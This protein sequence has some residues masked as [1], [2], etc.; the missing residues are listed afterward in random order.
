MLLFVNFARYDF[1]HSPT[2][3]GK[4][5]TTREKICL[6]KLPQ[7]VLRDALID[8]FGEIKHHRGLKAGGIPFEPHPLIPLKNRLSH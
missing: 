4:Q 6:S 5:N 7:V 2:S 8:S 3:P 1:G